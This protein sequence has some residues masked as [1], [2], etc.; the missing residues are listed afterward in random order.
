VRNQLVFI[1]RALYELKKRYGLP[2]DV[3]RLASTETNLATGERTRV[4]SKTSIVRAIVMDAQL[5]TR[6][7]YDLAYIMAARQ[8]SMGGFT[9]S[10][11][12]VFIIDRDDLASDFQINTTDYIV[13][14]GK[15]YEIKSCVDY[16][17]RAAYLVTGRHTPNE[18][19]NQIHEMSVSQHV[20]LTHEV[21]DAD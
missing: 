3:Y 9:D 14:D 17:E 4:L 10:A 1:R 21:D 19:I 7:H 18:P 5:W 15:K 6:F 2:I 11:E 16:E 13:F 12:R 8:F 20:T